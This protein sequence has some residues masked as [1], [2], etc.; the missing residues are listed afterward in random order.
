MCPTKSEILKKVEFIQKL[1]KM[2]KE[3][4]KYP[5]KLE[6]SRKL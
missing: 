2:S 1:L 5:K 6:V 4:W 3:I